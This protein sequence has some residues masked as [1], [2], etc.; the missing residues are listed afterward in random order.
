MD[1]RALPKP[2]SVT[3]FGRTSKGQQ[4]RFGIVRAR[5]NT[6]ASPCLTPSLDS[7]NSYWVL[8]GVWWCELITNW[9]GI[10]QPKTLLSCLATAASWSTDIEGFLVSD[11]R[12]EASRLFLL[13]DTW[14]THSK[15]P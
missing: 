14:G 8:V 7:V 3:A 11:Y 1:Y 4:L 9:Y 2:D 5:K 13:D 15:Y 12:L 6:R 10:K